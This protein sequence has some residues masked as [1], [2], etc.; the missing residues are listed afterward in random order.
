MERPLPTI[1]IPRPGARPGGRPGGGGAMSATFYATL[2]ADSIRGSLP[3]VP[4]LLP[5]T[6]W[7]RRGFRP[8][9][10][11][12]HVAHVAVD[13]GAFVA[14]FRHG[15]DYRY[16]PERY[17]AWLRT[18]AHVPA[19][20]AT[21]DYCCEPDIAGRAGVV[22][23][24]QERTT[25]MTWLFWRAYRAAPWCWVP[26]VQGWDV[27]DYARHAIEL[28]PLVEEMRAHYGAD[29]SG[30]AFRVGVGTLC[31]R[32]SARDI[33]DV[34][35]VVAAALP[36]TPL[37]LWGV[38]LTAISARVG[39]LAAVASV[40]SAAWS[41]VGDGSTAHCGRRVRDSDEWRRSGLSR[42]EWRTTVALPHYLAKVEAGLGTP[43]QLPL[44]MEMPR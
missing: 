9:R 14:T 21:M 29:G 36:D 32:A 44:E 12:A 22:R 20:A 27:G 15:G 3:A 8:V 41:W 13:S 42:A 40:D 28:R 10:L 19:W 43:K 2:D 25:E 35:R 17:V 6:A 34:V 16:T 31:R 4:V 30:A 5:A 33:H 39:L 24:R 1:V 11:P 26:T 18:I 38:K 37:H 23:E 7:A